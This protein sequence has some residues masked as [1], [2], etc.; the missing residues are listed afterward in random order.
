MSKRVVTLL[1]LL[2]S[3]SLAVPAF[4]YAQEF[5]PQP[6]LVAPMALLTFGFLGMLG[7]VAGYIRRNRS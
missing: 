7:G 6:E 1:V 4:A 2:V 3:I 5:I